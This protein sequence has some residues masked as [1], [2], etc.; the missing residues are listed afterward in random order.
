M[1]ALSA[2]AIAAA[3]A[4]VAV[5]G[6]LRLALGAL[7]R[8]AARQRLVSLRPGSGRVGRARLRTLVTGHRW[9]AGPA[10]QR[11]VADQLPV[12][13]EAVARAVR[14]GSSLQQACADAAAD[15]PAAAANRLGA[16]VGRAERGQSLAHAFAA[17][18]A[19]STGPE[20][21]LAAGALALA[22]TAG[23]PQARAVDSV[24]ATLRE[25]RAI[26]AEVRAQSAQARLSAVIIGVLPV[27]F[28]LWAMATDRR[29]AAFLV[30]GPSGWAC[31]TAGLGLE[32]TGAA[33]MRRLLRRVGS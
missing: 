24:A 10:D 15:G 17:W 5:A 19:A 23:G 31:L 6:L 1:A 18:A 2:L 20:E 27:V 3:A 33:F 16:A 7:P 21:R 32:I 14:A 11:R 4:V 8:A 30:A 22:A 29:T 9:P 13:L 26:A 12:A 25:R 28:L